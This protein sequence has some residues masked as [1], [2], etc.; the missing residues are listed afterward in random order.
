MRAVLDLSAG[1]LVFD[2]NEV[3]IVA[4]VCCAHNVYPPGQ[5]YRTIIV[6]QYHDYISFS[7]IAAV[8][9]STTL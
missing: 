1:K 4:T 3:T 2:W 7:W 9:G 5:S 6:G 8:A